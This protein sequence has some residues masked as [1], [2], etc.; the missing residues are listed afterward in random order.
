[1]KLEKFIQAKQLDRRINELTLFIGELEYILEF[2]YDDCEIAFDKRPMW[3][4]K[5]L[6]PSIIKILIE[7]AINERTTCKNAFDAL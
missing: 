7:D 5:D 2:G 1:M 3:I 6:V 4:K